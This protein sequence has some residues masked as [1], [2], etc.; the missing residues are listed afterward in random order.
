MQIL[1]AYRLPGCRDWF[2]DDLTPVNGI[3]LATNCAI[4]TTF[5]EIPDY[6]FWAAT[7]TDPVVSVASVLNTENAAEATQ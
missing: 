7:K 1:S 4:G 3:R 5:D 6:N 2:R